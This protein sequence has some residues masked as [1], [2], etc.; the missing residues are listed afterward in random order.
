MK[1]QMT[2]IV[3][4][5]RYYAIGAHDGQGQKRKF[6]YTPYWHHVERVATRL[7]AIV[8]DCTDEMLAA[9]YLHD[10]VEDTDVTLEMIDYH[11]GTV[12]AR[13]VQELTKI[14]RPE[15]G[16]RA[17]RCHIDRAFMFKASAEAQTIKCFDI[18]DNVRDIAEQNVG[19]GLKY[20][21]E[22]LAMYNVLTR[23]DPKA[24]TYCLDAL[25]TAAI[26]IGLK[27]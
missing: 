10:T 26:K 8:P 24:R 15:D 27:L 1:E 11:F 20:V 21:P 7:N 14:S 16:N 25:M 9:A 6:D 2:N 12:T 17:E 4:N 18:A 3:N 5:A 19:F 13:L 23:A 22:K